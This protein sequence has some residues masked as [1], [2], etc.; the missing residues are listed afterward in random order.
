MDGAPIATRLLEI[1]EHGRLLTP[2]ERA[3]SL[4]ALAR[5]A[6]PDGELARLAI[7]ARDRELLALRERLF[8]PRLTALARC[9]ACGQDLELDLALADI[10]LPSDREADRPQTL[11]SDGYEI[12]FRLPTCG[13]L[14]DLARNGP[15]GNGGRPE[16]VATETSGPPASSPRGPQDGA[17]D[18]LRRCVLEVRRNGEAADGTLPT[19]VAAAV[20]ARMAELDPQG[21]LQLDLRCPACAHRWQAPLDI[22]SYLWSE[23]HA[24][25]GRV[26]REVHALASA[27]GWRE[28]DILAM[29]PVRRQ[30]YLELIGP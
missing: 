29:S 4:L 5:P 30:A 27:Y 3:Q 18:L 9:P 26:L 16:T 7:G 17:S 20:S 24:W 6:A 1:W 13:D 25:A 2:A 12:R 21:D 10:R 11:R 22:A 15:A 19:A 14:V 23:I 28:A 8:G